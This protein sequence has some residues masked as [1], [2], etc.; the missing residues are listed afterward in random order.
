MI[1]K[2]HLFLLA[3]ILMAFGCSTKE[4]H[5]D[6]HQ[7]TSVDLTKGNYNVIKSNAVGT[8]RGLKILGFSLFEPS[9]V[10]AM[11]DLR[12]Q[13]PMEGKSA[14]VTN[15]I[16]EESDTWL[17]LFSIPKVTVSADIVE[18]DEATKAE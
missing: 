6:T 5:Y 13:A 7:A 17:L 11:G 8:D 9:M 3:L 10:D 2:K 1:H 4:A 14:A 12:K 15:V 16:Q 18:F